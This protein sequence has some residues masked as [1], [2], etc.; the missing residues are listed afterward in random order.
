MTKP[1]FNLLI[2]LMLELL[3]KG[4]YEAVIKLLEDAKKDS[5]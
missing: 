3:K 1:E 4:E 2:N 5:K